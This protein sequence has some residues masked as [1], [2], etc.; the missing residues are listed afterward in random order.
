MSISCRKIAPTMA[1][2]LLIAAAHLGCSGGGDN[3]A[4]GGIGGT[5][6]VASSVG[7]VTAFGSVIVNGVTYET[8]GAE[9]FVENTS[10]GSGDAALVQNLSVGMVVRVEGRLN[11]NGSASADRVLY[12]NYLKGPVES[13]TELDSR[14]KQVVILDQTI[15]MDDRTAFRGTTAASISIGMFVEVSGYLD[16]SGRIEATYIAKIV[17]ALPA[18]RTLQI[19]GVVQDLNTAAKTFKINSLAVDYATADLSKL[20]GKTPQEGQLLRITGKLP[21]TNVLTAEVLEPAE[22][23]G[24]A[25][26]DA[27]DLEGIITQTRSSAEFEI[28]RYTIL[29]DAATAY[30]N[31]VP[32]DLNR[33]TRVVVRGALS[34]RSILAD[35]ISL[36]EKIR[37]ESNVASLNPLEKSLLL[38]GLEAIT[39]LTTATTRI[40]GKA[41]GLD[42]ILPDDHIRIVGRRSVNGD[43]LATNLLVTPSVESVKITGPVESATPPI[44][45]ILGAAIN[46]GSV[47]AEGFFGRNGKPVSEDAF[48][49]SV[50]PDDYVTVEGGIQDGGVSWNAVGFE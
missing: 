16:E 5:G 50:K 7:T 34:G 31:L 26:F 40:N 2:L 18:D 27:V 38:S 29:T 19:K 13:I 21:A 24:S 4:G 1:L 36:P 39:V 41:A 48:F 22:E 28:G 32:H 45:V 35:E 8:T 25:I 6:V 20:P 42:Q 14:S 47:P 3:Y 17:D 44:L 10:K 11:A 12:G 30:T 33:G 37:L 46:T 23:F 9:V 49:G 15:L 43:L